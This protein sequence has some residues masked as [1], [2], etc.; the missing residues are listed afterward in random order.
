M[1]K[2]LT[3]IAQTLRDANKKVQLIYA[4]NGTGKTRLSREFKKLIPSKETESGGI[5]KYYFN[6][7]RNI[8]EKSA[9]FPGYDRW[10]DLL[11]NDADGARDGYYKRIINFSSHSKF[12]SK[13]I[14]VI[15]KSEKS[16]L[17]RLVNDFKTRHG[18]NTSTNN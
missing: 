16:M 9:T 15:S 4:F 17:A 7:F 18:F 2:T 5:Q 12:A 14:P 3:E 13:K 8:L 10:E 6:I 11:S 1:G